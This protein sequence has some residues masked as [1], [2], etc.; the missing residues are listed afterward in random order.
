MRNFFRTLAPER[1]DASVA[2]HAD[3][4]YDFSYDGVLIFVPALIK[5][6]RV[7]RLGPRIDAR[8]K[9]ATKQLREEGFRSARYLGRGRYAVTLADSRTRGQSAYFPSREMWVFSIRPQPDGTICIGASRPDATAPCQLLGTDAEIDGR[10]NVTI[11]KGVSVLA[12][13]AARDSST[14]DARVEH[15]W[16][17]KSPDDDPFMVVRPG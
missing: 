10:L 3:G 1:F 9:G 4:S 17:I 7:G 14:P 12:H 6:Y 15:H 11:E 16:R 5:A 2:I 8:L 13:N